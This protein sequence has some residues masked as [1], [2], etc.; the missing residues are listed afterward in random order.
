M[1]IIAILLMM[2]IGSF[3]IFLGIVR[4][5]D[6]P[7]GGSDHAYHFKLIKFIKNNKH[8]LVS[9]FDSFNQHIAVCPQLYHWICSF[10]SD[11]FL[12]RKANWIGY[13]LMGLMIASFNGFIYLC[14]LYLGLEFNLLEIALANLLLVTLPIIYVIWNAKFMGLSARAFGLLLVYWYLFGLYFYLLFGGVELFLIVLLFVFF[15]LLGS[16]FAY[17]FVLFSSVF[18]A[19]V[20]SHYEILWLI[21]LSVVLLFVLNYSYALGFFTTQFHHK[22]NYAKFMIKDCHFKA[23]FS[24][25]RDFVYD[26]WIKRDKNYLLNNP[27]FEVLI[28]AFAACVALVGYWWVADSSEVEVWNL[29]V[30][31]SSSFF[32]FLVTS[33][34]IA[35]FLGEPQRYIEFGIPFATLLCV[36]LFPLW[37]NVL[38][39]VGNVWVLLWYIKNSQFHR[40]LPEHIK[41]REELMRDL[42]SHF[43]EEYRHLLSND[44][45]IARHFYITAYEP[46][47]PNYCKFYKDREDFLGNYYQ[48]DYHRISP[49]YLLKEMKL[50]QR[51]ILIL[52]TNLLKFYDE[53]AL[54]PSLEN[55]QLTYLKSIGKF[56][57]FKFHPKDIIPK[58]SL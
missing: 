45:E 22:R 20:S 27:V 46:H 49:Q 44:H 5:M 33:L 14:M 17:Q 7:Y 21:P 50:C 6:Y 38:L 52:Y 2:C 29:Y 42:Q 37:V 13:V 26:F 25:W 53:E 36:L 30:L 39:I 11:C 12:L 43:N 4:K 55:I 41:I 28:G 18:I 16:Q 10:F 15:C 58:E 32:A 3:C 23:R 56:K 57:I 48:G 54:I 31:L 9:K 8:W 1:E 40:Q 35:R 34:R 24:I 51:G 47:M 19:V